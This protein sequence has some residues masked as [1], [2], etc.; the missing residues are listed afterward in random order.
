MSNGKVIAGFIGGGLLLGGMYGT[1]GAILGCV[2]GAL[3]FLLEKEKED[4]HE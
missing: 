1:P 4:Y 3:F 2:I